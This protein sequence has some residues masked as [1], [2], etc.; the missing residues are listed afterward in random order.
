ML[1][2]KIS[3]IIYAILLSSCGG[4]KKRNMIIDVPIKLSSGSPIY[5]YEKK[6][7]AWVE[8]EGLGSLLGTYNQDSKFHI[9]SD[10]KTIEMWIPAQRKISIVTFR[11]KGGGKVD[12]MTNDFTY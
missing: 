7:E 8:N 3:Y 6:G 4:D 5:L 11:D 2:M 10:N 9:D 12:R 1:D